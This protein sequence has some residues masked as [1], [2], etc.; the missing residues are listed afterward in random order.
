M[1]I[2]PDAYEPLAN[3]GIVLVRLRRYSEADPLLRSALK[4]KGDSPIVHFYLGRALLGQ[5]KSEDAEPVFRSA[6]EKGGN[7]MIEARR[8]LATIY[9]E[10]GENEKAVVEIEAYLVGNPTAYDAK[11]LQE[12][13]TKIKEW[14]KA[15]PKP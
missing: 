3:R 5:K 2:K 12:T 4:L 10:R 9:L 13:V 1:K 7:D 11:Q 6:F 14:L 8:A 15:N